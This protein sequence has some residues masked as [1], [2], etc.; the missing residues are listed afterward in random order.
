MDNSTRYYLITGK[1][2]PRVRYGDEVDDWNADQYDCHDCGAAEGDYHEPGCD[3]EEC[4]RCGSQAISCGC[5][6]ED[7]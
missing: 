2:Y 5:G 6:D 4:P 1:K 7:G 3:V